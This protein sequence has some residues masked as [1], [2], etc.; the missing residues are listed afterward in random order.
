[1]RACQTNLTTDLVNTFQSCPPGQTTQKDIQDYVMKDSHSELYK[2]DSVLQSKILHFRKSQ[3]GSRADGVES[4]QNCFNNPLSCSAQERSQAQNSF[5]ISKARKI[6]KDPFRVLDAPN[7]CDDFY[8]NLVD[9]S[10]KNVLAVALGQS[11]YIWNACTS[12]VDQLCDLPEHD[13]VTSVSWSQ[14]GHYLSVG[15][16]G[17]EVQVWDVNHGKQV[18]NLEGHD[19]RVGALSWSGSM[20]ASGSKDKSILVRDVRAQS[21]FTRRL[22][23][24]K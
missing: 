14:K 15:T 3:T 11:V 5:E 20:I 7:L 16:L 9:W 8:L 23:G 21:N 2:T 22:S 24:H 19:H 13:Q 18:R 17:G 4:Q 10:A 12:T 1:M 6:A